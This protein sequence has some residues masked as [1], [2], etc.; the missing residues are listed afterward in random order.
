MDQLTNALGQLVR[1][2]APGDRV[3][4]LSRAFLWP[5]AKKEAGEFIQTIERQKAAFTL[6]I[7]NDNMY[8][9]GT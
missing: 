7:Q 2:L 9:S 6:A 4:R 5:L 3:Q 1:S 8:D